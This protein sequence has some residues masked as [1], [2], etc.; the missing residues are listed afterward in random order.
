MDYNL[1]GKPSQS[2]LLEYIKHTHK[3]YNTMPSSN[4]VN[5]K[6][7]YKVLLGKDYNIL[8]QELTETLTRSQE[9][10]DDLRNEAK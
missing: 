2:V 3:L 4:K 7:E 8:K 9:L 1:E 10:L 5:I 6:Q